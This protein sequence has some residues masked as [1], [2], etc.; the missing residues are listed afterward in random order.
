MPD[1]LSRRLFEALRLEI[2]YDGVTN[3]A[4]CRI[5]LT[6]DTIEAVARATHETAA[7]H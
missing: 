3:E 6:G 5:T 2:H 7:S 1:E 4:L